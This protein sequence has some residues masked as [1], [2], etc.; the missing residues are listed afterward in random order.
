MDLQTAAG[1]V[2][3]TALAPAPVARGCAVVATGRG[4][5]FGYDAGAIGGTLSTDRIA[6]ALASHHVP[7]APTAR[8]RESTRGFT[9]KETRPAVDVRSLRATV[10]LPEPSLRWMVT[11]PLTGDPSVAFQRMARVAQ[12]SSTSRRGPV[13]CT[14][15]A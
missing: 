13:S 3:M 1:M 5:A 2:V 7:A 9:R 15:L 14:V 11:T 6:E 10:H 8:H 4:A 12:C